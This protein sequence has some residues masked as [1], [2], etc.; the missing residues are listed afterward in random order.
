[1]KK[2]LLLFA[3]GLL[4]SAASFA[5]WTAPTAKTLK[6][7]DI[8]PDQ[9][10]RV[11]NVE[12]GAF[13]GG[14]NAWGTQTSLITPGLDYILEPA[15]GGNYKFLTSS[16]AKAGKYMFRDNT[17]G[18]F[19]D[20][21]TQNRGYVWTI[22]A[23]ESGYYTIKSPYDDTNYGYDATEGTWE[24][25][26]FGW[27]GDKNIVYA[28]VDPTN[29]VDE[30]GNPRA[31][32]IE[33]AFMTIEEAEAYTEARAPYDAAMALK[34][35]IDQAKADYPTVDCSKAEA[36]YN[37][38]NSTVEELNAAKSLVANAI[39]A[40][41]TAEVLDG[42]SADDPR[43]GT[44]LIE[45]NDFSTGDISGWVCTFVS[46]TSANNIG[47][48][49][50]SYTGLNWE[51]EETGENGT[52]FFDKFIEAWA[53]NVD[54][55]KRDGK[56]FATIGDAKLYQ[57]IYG[58]PAGKYKLSCDANA[59]QQWDSS[60]NPVTGV[61]LYVLGGEI[62]SHL[63]MATGNGI[64]EHFV[65]NF[66]HS[67][68]D[69][70]L[71]LRTSNTTANWIGA[72]N[73][74]LKYYGPINEN[75]YLILLNDSIASL[76]KKYA[77]MDEVY[78]NT[79]VKSEF[80]A[81]LEKAQGAAANESD[82]YYQNMKAELEAAAAKLAASVEAYKSFENAIETAD[83]KMTE[84]DGGVWADLAGEIA[85]K[86]DVWKEAYTEGTYTDEEAASKGTELS[87][88][89][90][91]F[92]SQHCEAGTDVT[93]LLDNPGFT[94]DFSGWTMGGAGVVWQNNY[95]NGEN[96]LT[97]NC[98][99]PDRNDGLAERWHAKFTMTQ[100]IK[101]MPRGLYTLTCQGFN[102]HDDGEDDAAA[103]LYAVL[104]NGEI[105]T[106][107][108]AG[109]DDYA[110]EE[111]LFS[112][113]DWQSDVERGGGWAPNSMTGSAWHFMNKKDGE[114]YDYVSKFDIVMT[115]A[116]DLTMGARCE[117]EH[118]WVIFDNFRI[119]YQGSG[120][121]V[122]AGVLN[123]KIAAVQAAEEGASK[124]AVDSAEDAVAQAQKAIDGDS[125]EDCIEALKALNA[126]LE[127]LKDSKGL[128]AKLQE[129]YDEMTGYRMDEVDSSDDTFSTYLDEIA[130]N[131]ESAD[132]ES[133]AAVQ[134][135]IDGIKAGFTTYV[136]AG[137]K[138]AASE[139]A[140]ADITAVIY[141]PKAVGLVSSEASSEYWQTN[142]GT[143]GLDGNSFELY[144]QK[145]D[146]S[147]VIA[148]L[149]PGYYQLKV[150]GFY[151]N[152]WSENV[153]KAMRGETYEEIVKVD[154]IATEPEVITDTTFATKP[155]VNNAAAILYAGAA[156]TSLLTIADDVVNYTTQCADVE[157]FG[158]LEYEIDAEGTKATFINS[159]AQAALAFENELYQN[160]LQFQVTEQ[161][162]VVIGLKKADEVSGDWTIF[163]NW[164]LFYL[165]TAK[166]TNDPTTEIAGV[167]VANDG[168]ATIYD[169]SGRKVSK[170]LKGIYI[171]N[172]KKVVK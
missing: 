139:D 114:N 140:P 13:L 3:A 144:N 104:P 130:G 87:E 61:Q 79:D 11:L 145:Y 5:Q 153:A 15:D 93:V 142:P 47:Y 67:G 128:I 100:T 162:D 118:Q 54:A 98:E 89:I 8:A 158:G 77:D 155:Y 133:D 27:S 23:A 143:F 163:T 44:E 73:F 19:I 134:A 172:G 111:Q 43:D 14:A 131:L 51:D 30:E 12:Y 83:S 166:P 116:G 33:W 169:L 161:G 147:Q 146:A 141:N 129:A 152:G 18:C 52:A 28:N 80:S 68:G 74:T 17:S 26:Y 156:E 170:A 164:Q 137:V 92:I 75:P 50:A 99:A 70:E 112:N 127:T 108:F 115:E 53:A 38:P 60:Q 21:G 66:I 55:M 125:E 57:T 1:M 45:N 135:Y 165:G 2:K 159:M 150:Q 6:L 113:G 36:V 171:M 48:Q 168:V 120:P 59:V 122:Y 65:L 110:T 88:M 37:N 101:N 7:E 121:A 64:P 10:V 34:K 119:I 82:E 117:Y 106:A 9:K 85:D 138:D 25:E 160:V 81:A 16:G 96:S 90:A 148:N 157:G 124:G 105:Q 20:M 132:F 76:E 154:T 107:P 29:N 41:H 31:Y 123:E 46:G 136:M 63:D 35:V 42:A 151:R 95:G 24:Y 97:P 102:R 91:S 49:G 94:K 78:A 62:D 71:G 167:Q 22:T 4:A 109:I 84:M 72:D 126:A 56:T 86:L 103:E 32:G 39:A 149:I 69:V 58:L 40:V